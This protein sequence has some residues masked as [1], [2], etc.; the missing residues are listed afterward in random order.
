[1]NFAQKVAMLDSS[2][3]ACFF[4]EMFLNASRMPRA[5]LSMCFWRLLEGFVAFTRLNLVIY[6]VHECSLNATGGRAR[7]FFEVARSV[8]V[9]F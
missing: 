6:G 8:P 9:G 3:T 5:C 4:Y 2:R 1:M 7:P